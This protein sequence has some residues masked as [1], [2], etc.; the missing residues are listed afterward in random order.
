MH[1]QTKVGENAASGRQKEAL[2]SEASDKLSLGV[3]NVR[4]RGEARASEKGGGA[5]TLRWRRPIPQ[6][7][8]E[9]STGPSA[10][11]VPTLPAKFLALL[12]PT[13]CLMRQPGGFPPSCCCSLR[14]L[15]G[16]QSCLGDST[17]LRTAL[18]PVPF[19]WAVS[20]TTPH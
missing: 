4:G 7:R 20:G 1:K 8:D 13:S 15:S 3:G 5:Q 19:F 12:Q 11:F 9:E 10:V 17:R 14:L 6:H 2:A 16:A 18:Q